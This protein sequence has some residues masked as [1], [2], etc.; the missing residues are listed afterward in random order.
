MDVKETLKQ[1][2]VREP[3]FMK[4]IKN[5]DINQVSSNYVEGKDPDQEVA[6]EFKGLTAT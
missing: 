6:D 2:A 3:D 5:M 4:Y 1:E